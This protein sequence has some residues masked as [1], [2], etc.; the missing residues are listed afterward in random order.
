MRNTSD[1][2]IPLDLEMGEITSL[3]TKEKSPTGFAA[4]PV[5]R[6]TGLNSLK[7]SG[8]DH[9]IVELIVY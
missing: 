2:I 9:E 7:C 8:E 6:G 1:E 3:L 5:V 4:V